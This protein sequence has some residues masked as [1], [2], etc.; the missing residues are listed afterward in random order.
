MASTFRLVGVGFRARVPKSMLR[1]PLRKHPTKHSDGKQTCCAEQWLQTL[2]VLHEHPICDLSLPVTGVKC[3][4][5][6]AAPRALRLRIGRGQ[7]C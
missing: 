6:V 5:V 3:L 4:V 1:R 7:L 2:V